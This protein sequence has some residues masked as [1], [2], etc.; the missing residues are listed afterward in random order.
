M[1]RSAKCFISFRF[2]DQNIYILLISLTCYMPRPSELRRFNQSDNILVTFC[3]SF[4]IDIMNRSIATDKVRLE[5]L[6]SKLCAMKTGETKNW[7]CFSCGR[8][9]ERNYP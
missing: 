7:T 5:G 8:K 3:K 4:I 1:P 9:P 2:L 6:V